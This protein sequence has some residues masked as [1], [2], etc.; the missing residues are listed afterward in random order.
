MDVLPKNQDIKG[1]SFILTPSKQT[2]T[3]FG[4]VVFEESRKAPQN[5]RLSL[6]KDNS[7]VQDIQ[8]KDGVS[9]FTLN[10]LVER[11]TVIFLIRKLIIN[12]FFEK[13]LII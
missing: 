1:F 12:F 13:W 8:L 6:F 4:K 11:N 2:N 9:V 5:F 3:L 7:L 10:D